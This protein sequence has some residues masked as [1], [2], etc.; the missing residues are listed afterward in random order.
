M[1]DLEQPGSTIPGRR[2]R[3]RLPGG[4]EDGTLFLHNTRVTDAGLCFLSELRD[5]YSLHLNDTAVTDAGLE[6]L[7]GFHLNHVGLSGTRVT[8][9]AIERLRNAMPGVEFD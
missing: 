9:A 7:R 5:L 6:H 3:P 2:L 8:P 1:G 4:L